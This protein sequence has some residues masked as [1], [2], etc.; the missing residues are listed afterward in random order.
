MASVELS[1][2]TEFA[3]MEAQRG[4]VMFIPKRDFNSDLYLV[5]IEGSITGPPD[6]DVSYVDGYSVPITCASGDIAIPGC[7]VELFR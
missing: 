1:S 2:I 4:S 6:I 5:K 3:V 7:N